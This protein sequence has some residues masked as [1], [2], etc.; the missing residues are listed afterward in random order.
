MYRRKKAVKGLLSGI[1]AA[2]VVV[3]TMSGGTATALAA[4]SEDTGSTEENVTFTPAPE[5]H[6]YEG[7]PLFDGNP[8]HYEQYLDAVIDYIGLEG[9]ARF[10]FDTR[11]DYVLTEGENAGRTIPGAL[12]FTDCVQGVSTD[13]PSIIGLGQTWNKDLVQEA[14]AVIGNEK[15]S[16]VDYS[17]LSNI[18]VMACTAVSDLRINPLSGRFDEDFSEDT[19]LTSV[20]VDS[21]ATG[22]SGIKEEENTDGFWQK[23][24]VMTKHYTTY[25]AQAMRTTTSNNA[26][27]RALL[28]YQSQNAI[29]G[30]KSGALAGFMSSYGNTNGIPNFM[31]PLINMAKSVSPYGLYTL[32]DN[33]AIRAQTSM[34][35]GYDSAYAL[36]ESGNFDAIGASMA[37][38]NAA[39]ASP[40]RGDFHTLINQVKAGTYGVTQEEVEEVAKDQIGALVRCGILNEDMNDYP[41]Y[42]QSKGV[43]ETVDYNDAGNQNV[44]LQ[45]AQESVVLLKN[46]NDILPL[47]KDANVYVSGPMADARFQTTYAADT[48]EDLEYAGY[49]TARGISAIGGADNVTINADGQIVNIKTSSGKYLALADP[50]TGELKLTDNKEEAAKFEK[51]SWGQAEGYSYWCVDNEKWLKAETSG[52][53]WGGGGTVTGLKANGTESLE[54]TSSELTATYTSATMPTR[55]RVETNEDGTYT[56]VLNTYSESFMGTAPIQGYYTNGVY[57]TADDSAVGISGNLTDADTAAE[58]R[59]DAAKFSEE[60][61]SDY[62][63]ETIASRS[64]YAVVVVG[65]PTRHSSGEGCDRS[66]LHLGEGQYEQVERIAE[67]YPGRTIVIVQTNYPEII[68]EI[69]DNDNVAAILTQ[70][71]GGQYGGYALGQIVYGDVAPTGKLTAT[72]YNTNDVLPSISEYSLPVNS[73][74]TLDSL[75]PRF[76]YDMTDADPAETGLTYMYTDSENVTYE[77][78]YGLT[79]SSFEYSG[80]QAPSSI[81]SDQDSFEVSVNVTNT[82]DVAT[83]DVAQVYIS[84]PGSAYGDYA[85]QTKLVAFEKVYLEPGETKKVTFTVETSDF[86]L[87][88]VNTHDYV[89]EAGNY[90]LQVGNSSQNILQSAALKVT[91]ENIGTLDASSKPV[92]VFD[93]SYA[94]DN[95]MYKEVSKANTA[96]SLAYANNDTDE[97]AIKNI[98]GS[99]YAVMSKSDG[100]WTA[101][102]NVDLDGVEKII[103]NVATSADNGTIELRTDSVDGD[104]IAEINFGQTSVNEY[105]ATENGEDPDAAEDI[106]VSELGYENIEVNLDKTLSGVH[107]VYVVFRTPDSRINTLQFVKGEMPEV[108]KETLQSLYDEVKNLNQEDYTES[109]WQDFASALQNAAEVLASDSV[110]QE[111]VDAAYNNLSIAYEKLEKIS[112]ENPNTPEVNKEQFTAVLENAKEKAEK[113][114]T[115]ES[116]AVFKKVL[117]EAIQLDAKEN[118]TQEEIDDMTER[119]NDA[120]AQ[121][122]QNKTD[123]GNTPGG[124]TPDGDS[125]NDGSGNNAD[126]GNGNVS[127]S[128]SSDGGSQSGNSIVKTGDTSNIFMWA[129]VA[130]LCGIAAIIVVWRRRTFR[131]DN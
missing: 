14:G 72:W 88:N 51:Y 58:L 59:T 2:T 101:M 131:M 94:S 108:N 121:L 116:W 9:A 119:L 53:G 128:D 34:S 86:A 102:K 76:Q 123:T 114:Y 45:T 43:G 106:F 111:T 67:A 98:A 38:A 104:L 29:R 28:E 3:G 96:V 107:D 78:G 73:G 125:G 41:F 120:I 91:G 95:V 21:M 122:V 100:S 74:V 44:A 22:A 60:I 103:A 11:G 42:D 113:D 24:A 48:P 5:G 6:V 126:T 47:S 82:G 75:D 61:V 83:S 8:D 18:N 130:G 69:E 105:Q 90:D 17:D 20:M 71:Y 87:W 115:S 66:D 62:G 64:D 49:S 33:G 112:E 35:N 55:I 1:L 124:D 63:S 79:Y 37:V 25:N 27:A 10:A 127:G 129:G 57:V 93:T 85:P 52:G 50:E 15:I 40:D 109:T 117:D 97:N 31:S 19:Y 92:N 4:G 46:D 36:S 26:S 54:Q 110:D 81:S 99:Y 32:G 65:A 70:P 77:F 23:A 39:G 80:L 7:M 16:T 84:N 68:Q 13:L 118:A 56:Y 30:F 12:N 89:V